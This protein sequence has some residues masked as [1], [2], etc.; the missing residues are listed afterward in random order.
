MILS[1]ANHVWPF[2][3]ECSL[4]HEALGLR[5]MLF[6]VARLL[7]YLAYSISLL[8][9]TVERKLWRSPV[10]LVAKNAGFL[11]V[12]SSLLSITFRS[13]SF[14]DIGLNTWRRG[15]V[16]FLDSR[17]CCEADSGLWNWRSCLASM[18]SW[19]MC[20]ISCSIFMIVNELGAYSCVPR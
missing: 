3:S 14:R 7:N 16:D 17:L 13:R 2:L 8:S 6:L 11:T 4:S 19:T 12:N 20:S 5:R 15:L 18:L 10:G 1:A 9:V